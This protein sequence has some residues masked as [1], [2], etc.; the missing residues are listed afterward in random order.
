MSP[1]TLINVGLLRLL[2]IALAATLVGA[3]ALYFPPEEF[4]KYSLV[5]SAIQIGCAAILSWP[6]QAY[7]RF[8]RESFRSTGSLGVALGAR[9][10]MH[11]VLILVMLGVIVIASPLLAGRI[12]VSIDNLQRFF[13]LAVLVVP[14]S[15]IGL[16]SAQA[17]GRFFAYGLA[18]VIQRILQMGALL[19]VMIGQP[20]DWELLLVFSL[21]GYLAV[22]LLAW[23]NI[24][25]K[26]LQITMSVPVVLRMLRYAWSLPLATLGAFLLQWMDLWFISANI[27]EAAVGHYAWAYNFT[28]LVT[29]VLVPLAAVLAPR[30]IDMEL[31]KHFEGIRE[32]LKAIFAICMLTGALLPVMVGALALIGCGLVPSKYLMSLPIVLVLTAALLCQMG[33]AFVEPIVYAQEKLVPKMAFIVAI[34]VIVKAACNFL[35]VDALGMLGS[36]ISTVMCY[37]I[38]MLLQWRLLRL[39][40]GEKIP[41][42]WPIMMVALTVML[43]AIS[44][45]DT[46]EWF[47]AIS[48]CIS[49]ALLALFR[50][51]GYFVALPVVLEKLV[52]GITFRWLVKA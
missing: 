50:S 17:C 5:F 48:A 49:I 39:H 46:H 30:A 38:G 4:G 43:M 1:K 19:A 15:E 27:N 6:N 24:P 45:Q 10:L 26:A 25:R 47:T 33:M 14:L 42:A 36:A 34:M 31:D 44:W 40:L 8:G 2:S 7:L 13:V 51:A 12:G 20:P 11:G 16:I 41:G 52:G 28:L 23:S 21:L 22:A 29:S 32:L 18:P 37:G 9:L 35:L 3:I